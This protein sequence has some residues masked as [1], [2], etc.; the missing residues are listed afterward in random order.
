MRLRIHAEIDAFVLDLQDR[1]EQL[2]DE[3]DPG[4]APEV[5]HSYL[6]QATALEQCASE[7]SALNRRVEAG[8]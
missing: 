4:N 7:L 1:A 5:N 8:E 3:I 2:R 6:T